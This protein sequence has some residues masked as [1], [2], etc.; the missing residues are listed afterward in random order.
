MVRVS[1]PRAGV[2]RPVA[3]WQVLNLKRGE[4]PMKHLD[5]EMEKLEQ[6]I[7][8]DCISIGGITLCTGTN[9]TG[10]SGGTGDTGDSGGD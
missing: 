7:A 8:P 1:R 4:S 6:R 3:S 10:E 9:D 5:L 2:P